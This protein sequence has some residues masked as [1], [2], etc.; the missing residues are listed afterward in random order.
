[1][2]PLTVMGILNA[3][4][5]GN[6]NCTGVALQTDGKI[7]VAGS[8]YQFEDYDYL[9]TDM[10]AARYN[11]DGTTDHT[12]GT[13]GVVV[14]DL[15]NNDEATGVVIQSNGKIVLAGGSNSRFAFV[16]Y[17]SD[18]ALDSTFSQNGISTVSSKGSNAIENTALGIAISGSR[19]YAVGDGK[20][21]GNLGVI[22]KYQLD[23]GKIKPIVSITTPVNNAIYAAPATIKINAVATD[24]DGTVI[25]VDIYNGT[26]LLKTETSV[27]Y[28]F[29]WN[30]VPAGNYSLTAVATDN[31]G[32][33]TASDTVK[34]SVIPHHAPTVSLI[35]PVNNDIFSGPTIIHLGAS[36]VDPEGTI[37][38]VEFYNGATLLRTE[39]FYPYTYTWIN[40]PAGKYTLTAVAT[41]NFGLATTSAAVHISVVANKKPTVI[42]ANL[43][44]YQSFAA[45]AAI[46]LIAMAKD[47][48]GTISKVEFYN[49]TAL[50][51]TQ[52]FVPYASTWKDVPAGTYKI[53]AKATDNLGLSATSAPVTITVT[54]PNAPIVSKRPSSNDNKTGIPGVI[55]LKAWPNPAGNTLIVYASGLSQNKPATISVVSASGVIMKTIQSSGLSAAVQIDVS[56]FASGIYTVKVA[57]ENKVLNKQFIKL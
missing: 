45:P 48:D 8:T 46:P 13:N 36:A 53:T 37:S 15:G 51:T 7:V 35:N 54:A 34:V 40:A 39:H 21:P 47:P 1:M 18:G 26:K 25:K 31:S 43:A 41:N 14:T 4:L 52:Y 23:E 42:I 33:T 49:G 17:T 16:R 28:G 22:V 50:L 24:P 38:K 44:N 32:N 27:P 10:V 11:T 56:S 30:N 29:S 19:L 12:F 20:Y 3:D 5:G 2:C 6:D 57:C 55:S 9:N